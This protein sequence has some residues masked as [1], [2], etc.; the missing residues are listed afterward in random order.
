MPARSSL[1][2]AWDTGLP[3]GLDVSMYCS[4]EMGNVPS[5]RC[6]SS[7]TLNAPK[8]AAPARA[9]WPK[10]DSLPKSWLES[11]D[12]LYASSESP[13]GKSCQLVSP[14][15]ISLFGKQGRKNSPHPKGILI[16]FGGGFEVEKGYSLLEMRL[17]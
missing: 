1:A 5:A 11:W 4:E 6:L 16:D 2:K 9:S 10:L 17:S 3:G 12:C 13:G 7:K 14:D 8:E 15:L